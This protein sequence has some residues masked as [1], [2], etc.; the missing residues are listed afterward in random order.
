[1]RLDREDVWWWNLED[2]SVFTVSSTYD[3]LEG[4]L[5]PPEVL[6]DTKLM[7]FSS[8]WKSTAPSKVVVFSWKLSLTGYQL[9]L[10][11]LGEGFYRKKRPIGV[12]FVI[13]QERLPLISFFIVCGPSIC[14]HWCVDG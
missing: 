7:V 9:R 10:I 14:G 11:S 4:L 12:F 1:V 5:F 13:K 2:D 6:C 8:L 3:R